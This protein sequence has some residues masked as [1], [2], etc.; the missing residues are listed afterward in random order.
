VSRLNAE[1]NR[2]MQLPEVQA[3]LPREGLRH[4][5]MTPQQFGDFVRAEKEKWGPIV[6]ATGAKA[7]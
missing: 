3:R 6:K 1:A 7:D 5:A 4:V 2:V